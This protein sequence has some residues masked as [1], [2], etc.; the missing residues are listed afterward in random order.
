MLFKKNIYD[1]VGYL[2]CGYYKAK[3]MKGEYLKIKLQ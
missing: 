2:R 3:Y 1:S